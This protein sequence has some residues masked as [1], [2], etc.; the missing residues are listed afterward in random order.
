VAHQKRDDF[1]RFLHTA[2]LVRVRKLA[3]E[4][5]RQ[6][7]AGHHDLGACDQGGKE[8]VKLLDVHRLA[9]SAALEES[10]EAV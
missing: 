8:P 10:S 2:E 7:F 1:I 3:A 9:A 6:V 4:H 5:L